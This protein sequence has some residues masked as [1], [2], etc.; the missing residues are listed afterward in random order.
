MKHA[1]DGN[2]VFQQYSALILIAFDTVFIFR[3]C[4]FPSSSCTLCHKNDTHVAHYNCDVREGILIL[5]SRY[6]TKKISN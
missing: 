5:F 6:V 3:Y 4:H 1:I 2:F